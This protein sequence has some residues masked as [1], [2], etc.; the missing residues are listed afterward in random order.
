MVLDKSAH[1]WLAK[2]FEGRVYF[3]EP[4]AR[5]TSFRVGGAVD[6]WVYPQTREEVIELMT[7]AW[8]RK[9][10]YMV[11]GD[12]TNL[13]VD[14]RG[15]QGIAINLSRC[16]GRIH[17]IDEGDI[18]VRLYVDAGVKTKTLCRFC[19]QNGY[20]GM[21]FALGIPGTVGGA[22]HMNAGSSLGWMSDVLAYIEIVYPMGSPKKVF[23][24]ELDA[25]YRSLSWRRVATVEEQYAAVILGGCFEYK[26]SDPAKL[27][28]EAR[29]II[30]VRQKSQPLGEKSAGCFF[31]NPESGRPAGWLIEQSGLKGR[32]CGDAMVSEK[33][34]NFIVNTGK[35]S[36]SDIFTLVKTVQ[37]TVFEK[38]QVM[39]EPEVQIVSEEKNSEK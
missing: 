34:A 3:N 7:G 5:H 24:E 12:G 14:D 20:E 17:V 6:A 21:N 8:Q 16:A 38:Y 4:M 19:L 33:H 23:K 30:R 1:Q 36:A 13:L 22:I 25:E 27:R 35:A 39:L 26:K 10:N 15:M 9:I 11:V 2:T 37:K 29:D 18:K 31:K 28:K 32:H